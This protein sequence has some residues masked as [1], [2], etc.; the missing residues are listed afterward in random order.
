M[1]FYPDFY[2]YKDRYAAID[3]AGNCLTYGDLIDF[4]ETM[5]EAVKKRSIVFVL[6]ENKMGSLAGCVAFLNNSVIP[7]L[8]D[9][10]MDRQLLWSLID[11]YKPDYLYIPDAFRAEFPD[12]TPCLNLH[13]Y[14]LLATSYTSQVPVHDDLALLVSTSGST[15]SPKLVRQSYKNIMSNGLAIINYLGIDSNERPITTLPMQYT[16]GFSIIN[17]HLLAGATVLLTTRTVVEKGLWDFF[18]EQ[19]ATSFGGVPYTL[20][21]LKRLRFFRM[22]LP[23]LKTITQAGGKLSLDLS[24]E[25]AEYATA[26]GI[27]FFVMYGQTEATARMSYLPTEYALSKCGSMGIAIP[28]GEFF[29]VDE[30]GIVIDEIGQEGELAYRGENVTL[31]YAECREDLAKGDERDGVL[32]TGDIAKRDQDGFYYVT[33]RK[34][35]FIKLFGNRVN[36]D[37]AEHLIKGLVSDCACCGD[38]DRMLIYVTGPGRED[39]LRQ[40]MASKTGIHFSAFAVKVISEIPKNESGKTQYSEIM[41]WGKS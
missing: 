12:F 19:K 24:R 31:G 2:T 40:L 32:F 39:E 9:A 1:S 25:F 28:G 38:D 16:Y 20:E 15:G 10:N 18:R 29:L 5:G 30:N 34:K 37:E 21:M 26:K 17:S 11:T 33:G 3:D 36:L 14:L 8:L 23:S 13:E 7:L 6:C 27:R 4:T 35:R 41:C 22:E